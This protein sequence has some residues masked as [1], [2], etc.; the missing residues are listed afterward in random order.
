M[1]DIPQHLLHLAQPEVVAA[2]DAWTA[3]FES[4]AQCRAAPGPPPPDLPE[5]DLA[6]YACEEGMRLH[7]RA[8]LA[9][10]DAYRR[11]GG[12]PGAPGG[13]YLVGEDGPEQLRPGGPDG[14]G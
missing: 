9:A 7:E 14:R 8:V 11:A 6:L 12:G 2:E 3:H 13:I 10:H 5:A 1:A 4:C